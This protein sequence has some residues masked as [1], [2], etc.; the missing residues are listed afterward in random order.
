MC[1]PGGFD[2]EII[3]H[4]LLECWDYRC[5]PTAQVLIKTPLGANHVIK[6]HPDWQTKRNVVWRH[7]S[8]LHFLGPLPISDP[9]SSAGWNAETTWDPQPSTPAHPSGPCCTQLPQEQQPPT[10]DTSSLRVL[11]ILGPRLAPEKNNKTLGTINKELSVCYFLG[12][13]AGT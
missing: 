3:L 4:P 12:G 1:R 7:L 2:P 10:P 5:K 8:G 9:S 11:V 13:G 6:Y